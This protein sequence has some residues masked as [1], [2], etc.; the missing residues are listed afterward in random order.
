M[1]VGIDIFAASFDDASLSVDS[2][3]WLRNLIKKIEL[4]DQMGLDAFG[5]GE[6]PSGNF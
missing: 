6:H 5:I 1:Q 3:E 2:S 4:D